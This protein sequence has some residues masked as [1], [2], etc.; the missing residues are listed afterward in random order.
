MTEWNRR[1]MVAATGAALVMARSG[2]LAAATAGP[3]GFDWAT[4][5]AR[6]QALSATPYR[7]VPPNPGAQAVDYDALNAVRF[8]DDRTLWNDRND[9]TGIRLFPLSRNANQPVFLHLVDRGQATPIAYDPGFFDMP[10]DSPVRALG[11][12]AGFAG[13]R[14]MTQARDADWLVYMGASYF[15]AAGARKQYGLSARAVAIDTSSGREEFPRFTH[16][17]LEHDGPAALTVYALLDGP[18][19]AG[20]YRFRN[21]LDQSGVHQDVDAALFPRR[22]IGELGLMPMTSMFWYDQAHRAGTDAR[23]TDWRPEIHDSDML[24]IRSANGAAQARPMVNPRAPHVSSFTE[25]DA[26]G[27]GLLQRDRNFDHYQDDGVFYDRR[28]SLFATPRQPLGGGKVRLYSFPATSEY[29]DNIAAYW[30]PDA[31]VAAGKRIDL[32]YRLDWQD[33]APSPPA[34]LASLA[35]V[36]RGVLES[37]GVRLVLDFAGGPATADGVAV[38]VDTMKAQLLKSAAYPVLGQTGRWRTVL[39]L[40]IDAGLGAEIRAQ[41]RQGDRAI[42][43]MVHYP[44]NP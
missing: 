11:K 17:W 30:V 43:E 20:A 16:F 10:D 28:P 37:G 29:D 5:V 21:R 18:G 36:F 44:L 41:L 22:A 14:V 35:D 23:A 39:D 40:R 8:R 31:P 24:L 15:R 32:G 33:D 26:R 34:A 9:A 4:L 1:E 27:F 38:H 42:S 25:P 3:Q 7:N 6:A 12:D 13:F 2:S 19:I